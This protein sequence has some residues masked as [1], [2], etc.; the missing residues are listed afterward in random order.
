[1]A[2]IPVV[3][4]VGRPNVGKSSLFNCLAKRRIAIVDDFS[5]VTRDR[6]STLIER[7]GTLFEI[8]DTGGIGVVDRDDLDLEI[9]TQ[10]NIAL[11]SADVIVFVVDA[12]QGVMPLDT[13][14]AERLRTLGKPVIFAANKA[15][16]QDDIYQLGE[17]AKLGMGEPLPI[18]AH[19]GFNRSTLIELI[20]AELP[21]A[22]VER[23]VAENVIKI[24]VVGKKAIPADVTATTPESI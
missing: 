17:F 24:A 11:E 12:R 13:T 1:M 8:I 4:I 5:G 7:E 21:Q 14:V 18:S 19:Q 20:V 3:A 9:S 16:K 10:I 22:H 23:A 15:E 2:D 6:I